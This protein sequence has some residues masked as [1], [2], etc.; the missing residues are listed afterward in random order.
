MHEIAK[1]TAVGALLLLI[2]PMML[3]VSGWHWC[4]GS[5]E[6]LLKGLYW[7][8]ATVTSPWGSSLAFSSA[9]GSCGAYA[10]APRQPSGW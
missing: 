9:P 5:N 1:R 10:Y 4:P 8:T 3:W 6:M 2:M 7:V